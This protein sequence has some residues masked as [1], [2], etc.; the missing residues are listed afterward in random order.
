VESFGILKKKIMKKEDT[1][2]ILNDNGEV[3][4]IG[5]V[6]EIKD[7]KVVVL[8]LFGN[9]STWPSNRVKIH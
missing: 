4:F 5:I 8:D 6:D 3:I 1:V 7:E 9:L 2:K